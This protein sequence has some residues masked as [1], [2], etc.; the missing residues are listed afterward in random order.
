MDLEAL[1]RWLAFIGAWLLF[2]GPIYQ[3]ALELQEEDIE[4]DR[5][6]AAGATVQKPPKASMWWWVF[7]PA[8]IYLESRRRKDFERRVMGALSLEDFEAMV[9]FRNKS[10]GWLY[11]A[12]GGFCIAC[13]ETYELMHANEWSNAVFFVLIGVMLVVSI[14]HLVIRVKRT[15]ALT[16]A[17][18]K[19]E[20]Q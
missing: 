20:T 8:K 12:L 3:A 7:P 2:A 18:A 10:N 14:G 19:S 15:S 5:I 6:R 4:I 17:A 9:S 11:V 1:I 16:Q 13:K